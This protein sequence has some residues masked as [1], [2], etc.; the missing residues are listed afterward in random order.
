MKITIIFVLFFNV[1]LS[2]SQSIFEDTTKIRWISVK[3]SPNNEFLFSKEKNRDSINTLIQL[4]EHASFEK[5]E[6]FFLERSEID[7]KTKLYPAIKSIEQKDSIEEFICIDQLSINSN[8][9]NENSFLIRLDD[10]SILSYEDSN[11][12]VVW[13]E[14]IIG[15]EC[16]VLAPNTSFQFP[17]MDIYN[18]K[19]REELKRNPINNQLEY[20]PVGFTFSPCYGNGTNYQIWIDINRLKKAYPNHSSIWYEYFAE[21]S[22][23]GIQYMQKE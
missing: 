11:D 2:F 21:K 9:N 7:Y 3:R 17:K 22:Y 15:L 19:I 6:I 13:C 5:K 16:I 10:D 18:I 14:G 20:L 8:Y 12:V 4:I 23:L 1:T